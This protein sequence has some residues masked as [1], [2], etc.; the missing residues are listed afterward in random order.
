VLVSSTLRDLVIGSELEFEDRGA[1][2]L[3]GVPG[4]WRLFRRRRYL[5]VSAKSV[6][7]AVS[8]LCTRCKR[9]KHFKFRGACRTAVAVRDRM[10]QIATHRGPVALGEAA[11]KKTPAKKA[12]KRPP[13]KKAAAK[14]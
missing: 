13:A 14:K 3:K 12:A 10:V 7:P 4:E 9:H 8:R 6:S 11:A 2:E 5:G 1:H